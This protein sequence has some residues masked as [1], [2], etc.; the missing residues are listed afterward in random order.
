MMTFTA[1]ISASGNGWQWQHA[2]SFW[3]LM[4]NASIQPDLQC[5]SAMISALEKS[6]EWQRALRVFSVS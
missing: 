4:H 1:A 2:I 6:H 5:F 3:E